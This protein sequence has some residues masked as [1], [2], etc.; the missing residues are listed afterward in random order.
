MHEDRRVQTQ[1]ACQLFK[2]EAGGDNPEIEG[3]N[4]A[5]IL[6]RIESHLGGFWIDRSGVGM[7][8]CRYI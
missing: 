8:R 7:T 5:E 6:A 1:R 4:Q 2:M 3:L